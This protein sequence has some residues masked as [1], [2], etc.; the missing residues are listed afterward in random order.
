MTSITVSGFGWR[1]NKICRMLWFHAV[2]SLLKL[3]SS[4]KMSVIFFSQNYHFRDV[5]S[6]MLLCKSSLCITWEKITLKDRKGGHAVVS[7]PHL[8]MMFLLSQPKTTLGVYKLDQEQWRVSQVALTKVNYCYS[9]TVDILWAVLSLMMV[10]TERMEGVNCLSLSTPETVDFLPLLVF[11]DVMWRQGAWRFLMCFS[12]FMLIFEGRERAYCEV[13]KDYK[14]T[15]DQ[16]LIE[17]ENERPYFSPSSSF[18]FS[19][20]TSVVLRNKVCDDERSTKSSSSHNWCYTLFHSLYSN[21]YCCCSTFQFYL[22]W[23]SSAFVEVASSFSL[24]CFLTLNQR[25]FLLQFCCTVHF[26]V[27]RNFFAQVVCRRCL[28]TN[29]SG[30]LLWTRLLFIT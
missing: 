5:L 22:T 18:L 23:F 21:P 27:T 7:L 17:S 15:D 14:E 16:S 11:H 19:R 13:N 28:L 12:C 30:K 24:H 10:Y 3:R 25:S 4:K 26:Y 9:Y 29:E 2:F 20:E 1:E 8:I 6:L